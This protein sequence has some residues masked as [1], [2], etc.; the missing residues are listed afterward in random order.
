VLRDSIRDIP[1][2]SLN[3]PVVSRAGG[4]V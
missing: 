1:K 3:G 4:V 2:L